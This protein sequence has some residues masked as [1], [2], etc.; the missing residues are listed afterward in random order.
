P[1]AFLTKKVGDAFILTMRPI[2]DQRMD[3]F[4]AHLVIIT[5]GIGTK[6]IVRAD[7]LFS[8]SIALGFTV[9]YMSCFWWR[10]G[11]R[12]PCLAIWTVSFC[13]YF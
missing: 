8:A 9:W 5:I 3:P 2:S 11:E 12:V 13:F 6:V 10:Y 1:F 4:I 7:L